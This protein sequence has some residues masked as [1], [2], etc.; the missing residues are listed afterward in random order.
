MFL[1]Q[2]HGELLDAI[3]AHVAKSGDKVLISNVNA[4]RAVPLGQ[5]FVVSDLD[6]NNL[7]FFLKDKL[8]SDDWEEVS[9]IKEYFRE[10]DK[11]LDRSDNNMKTILSQAKALHESVLEQSKKL[12]DAVARSEAALGLK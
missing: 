3:R 2:K 8:T 7:Q 6:W 10:L 1:D 5:G 9:Q 11:A 4:I 12:K